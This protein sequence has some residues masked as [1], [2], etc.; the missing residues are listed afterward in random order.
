MQIFVKALTGKTFILDVEP[1][2][3]IDSIKNKI[4]EK[5]GIPSI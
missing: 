5:E 4:N 3:S 1:S 2:D